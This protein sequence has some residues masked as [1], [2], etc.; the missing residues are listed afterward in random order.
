MNPAMDDRQSNTVC[1]VVKQ[2]PSRE[3]WKT[4]DNPNIKNENPSYF[5]SIRK[6]TLI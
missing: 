5:N 1:E 3:S 4:R 6:L 2:G